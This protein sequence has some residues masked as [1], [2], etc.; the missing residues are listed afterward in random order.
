MPLAVNPRYPPLHAVKPPTPLSHLPPVPSPAAR[1]W[2]VAYATMK[3]LTEIKGVSEAKA[4][5]IMAAAS[6]LVPMGF[7]TVQPLCPTDALRPGP[8]ELSLR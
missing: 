6:Q 7:S 1:R 5:K 2:Q 4:N 3:N 8:N